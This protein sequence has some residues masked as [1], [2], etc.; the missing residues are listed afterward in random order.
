MIKSVSDNQTEILKSIQELYC[1]GGFDCDL[2][3][4]NGG[5]WKELTQPKHCFDLEPLQPHV[6]KAN[7]WD[8]PL[9]DASLN[10]AVF[11]PPFLTYIKKGREHAGGK[12][13]M[14]QRFGGYYNYTELVNHYYSTL[15]ECSRLL[16][17]NGILVF[18]CQDIIHNHV[19][20]CT[21]YNVIKWAL[22]WN[23]RLEDLFILAK[24]HRMPR[25]QR[26]KQKHARVYH[27][28]FLVF[29]KMR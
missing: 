21:H 6:V 13:I 24:K 20:H 26:G 19:M 29:K 4:G 15:E 9:G 18:K 16:K 22:D 5:F 12:M 2:T 1:P 27:S 14:A 3:Y 10:N 11:D 25:P 17:K 23:F 8:V 28:Y 7:S